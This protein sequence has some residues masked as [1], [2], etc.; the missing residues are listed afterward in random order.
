MST[1][2]APVRYHKA[3]LAAALPRPTSFFR[4]EELQDL[5]ADVFPVL[6]ARE[7]DPFHGGVRSVARDGERRAA[8]GHAE[9]APPR[10]HGAPGIQ[11]SA[12]VVHDEIVERRRV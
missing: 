2:L 5:G 11:S 3:A 10:G 7:S 9:H 4:G 12:C 1:M 8:T 6:H